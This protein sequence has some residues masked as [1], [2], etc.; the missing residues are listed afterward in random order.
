MVY[1]NE[2]ETGDGIKRAFDEGIC[3]R[4]DLFVTSKLW[5]TYH[6]QEHVEPACRRSLEDLGLDYVDLYEMHF[7]ISLKYVPFDEML[8][9][10][11]WEHDPKNGVRLTEEPCTL[12]ETWAAM[13]D[14][15]D[16]DLCKAIGLA[17]MGTTTVRDICFGARIQPAV[18][19]VEIHPYSMQENLVRMCQERNIQVT[20]YSSLGA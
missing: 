14:L 1:G 15:V 8:N 13:E 5:N 19:Q 6:K 12:A 10:R 16:K 11:S 17:N 7:P 3:T 20:A 9:G 18:L 4:E 2:K